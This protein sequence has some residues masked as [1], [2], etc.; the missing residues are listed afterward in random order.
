MGTTDHVLRRAEAAP[1]RGGGDDLSDVELVI[2]RAR[3]GDLTEN[4]AFEDIER[5][6]R[7]RDPIEIY[8]KSWG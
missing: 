3:A 1:E 6:V 8:Q 7:R 4:E 5:I 2:S